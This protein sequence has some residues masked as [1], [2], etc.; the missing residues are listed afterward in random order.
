MNKEC[1]GVA[2]EGHL[3]SDALGLPAKN[4]AVSR[5]TLYMFKDFCD[6]TT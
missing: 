3:L 6:I 5:H 4:T 2:L 1:K